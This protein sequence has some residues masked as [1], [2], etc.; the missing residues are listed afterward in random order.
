[1]N[2]TIKL[3][4]LETKDEA[5]L[6]DE[7][8]LT[9]LVKTAIA[10]LRKQVK[11][12][13]SLENL[14]VLVDIDTNHDTIGK[15]GK[16]VV[17]SFKE[18][19]ADDSDVRVIRV[20][21]QALAN[22]RALVSEILFQCARAGFMTCD[23]PNKATAKALE[24]MHYKVTTRSDE[25]GFRITKQIPTEETTALNTE[26]YKALPKFR[27]EARAID[28]IPKRNPS[29]TPKPKTKPAPHIPR[30]NEEEFKTPNISNEQAYTKLANT[31]V[32]EALKAQGS[33]YANSIKI[34]KEFYAQVEKN[35]RKIFNQLMA[36]QAMTGGNST[37]PAEDVT[38]I[39]A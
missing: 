8:V 28:A 17:T 29:P 9:E 5:L 34:E 14:T 32:E 20:V 1:M 35:I 37:T 33:S 30:P 26:Y 15:N 12:A 7:R 31:L 6:H 24:A 38:E 18:V 13:P 22:P 16:L 39:A 21:L 2:T 3:S 27:C 11:C 36:N 10:N 19:K 23:K 4:T 25:K